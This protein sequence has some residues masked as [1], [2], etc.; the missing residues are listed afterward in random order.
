MRTRVLYLLALLTAVLL[1]LIYP[2][3][4]LTF[5]APIA[6]APLL[7]AVA[8]E[9]RPLRRFLLGWAAGIAYWAGVCYWI[10]YVLATHGGLNQAGAWAAFTL[11]CLLKAIHMGVFAWLAGLLMSKAYALPAVAALWVGIERTHGPFGFAWLTLGDAGTSMSLPMRL[12]PLIGVYGLSFAFAMMSA[13]IAL[14]VLRRPRREL[15]P[16]LL[17]VLLYVA[18]ELPPQ[19]PGEASAAVIQ[20]NISETQDWTTESVERMRRRL[21]LMSTREAMRPDAPR[22]DLILWPEVPAP[23]YYDVDP[24]FRAEVHELA[25]VTGSFFLFGTVIRTPEGAPLNSAAMVAPG[26]SFVDRYDKIFLVPFGEFVPRFLTF[27]NKISSETGDFAPGSRI[28]VFPIKDHHVATFICYESAFPHLIR[29]FA[30]GGAELFVNLSN[31]GYFGDRAAREQHL[32]LVRMRAAE[33]RRWIVRST[34][35]GITASIDPAGR[36]ISS[37]PSWKEVSGRL[38]YSYE[39]GQTRYAVWGDWFAW[40]CLGIS[41]AACLASQIPTYKGV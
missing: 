26:G 12:A 34:N 2:R 17:L 16:L 1:V 27:I 13:A 37:F 15:T 24:Q 35:N 33:N 31:D 39:S 4:E 28:V 29:R 22:P 9:P 25:R 8:R 41:I 14:L 10:Q 3:F 40:S 23:L 21:L 36:V 20:P 19:K 5:L 7:Y 6:L 38:S 11:F 30:A 32:R 18:P